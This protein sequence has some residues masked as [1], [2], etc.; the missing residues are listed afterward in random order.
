MNHP[1]ACLPI[2][3]TNDVDEAQSILSCELADL[4]IT[5]VEDRSAFHL[6]MSGA[7]LGRTM[8]AYNQFD[9][10]TLVDVGELEKAVLLIIG[11]G[12]RATFH[13]DGEATVCNGTGGILSPSRRVT[14]QRPA[15]SGTFIF[16][17][18][19][20]AIEQQLQ[21]VLDRHPGKPIVFDRSVDLASGVGAH[22]NRLLNSLVDNIQQDSTVVENPLLRAGFDEI[23]LN[24]L[25]A[26]PNNYSDELSGDHR[27]TIAPALVRKSEEFLEA[28][29][30]ESVTISNLLAQV[31]C[32]RAALF[33]AFRRYR[34]CTPMQFLAELR[35]KSAHEALQSPSPASTVTSI[36]YDCGFSHPGRFSAAYRKRFGESPLETLHKAE[37]TIDA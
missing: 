23:L 29:A 33:N 13:I 2:V 6:E 19:I 10:E 26:L 15:G 1:L 34:D 31:D 7:R 18:D 28:H 4:R 35:L 32:S 20:D 37:P 5:R 12:T 3:S 8:I 14:I 9:T 17:A 21:V 30:S 27:R 36:A 11:V 25:L 24:T 16:K 22:A